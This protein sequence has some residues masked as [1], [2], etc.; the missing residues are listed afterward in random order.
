MPKVLSTMGQT[1]K[2]TP[3]KVRLTEGQQYEAGIDP[4]GEFTSIWFF[5]AIKGMLWFLTNA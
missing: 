4:P 1:I 3:L 5:I 2:S